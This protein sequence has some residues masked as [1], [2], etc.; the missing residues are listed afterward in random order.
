[1][2][3]GLTFY[4]CLFVL[5]VFISLFASYKVDYRKDGRRD[6]TDNQKRGEYCNYEYRKIFKE[7]A[8]SLPAALKGIGKPVA[9][10]LIG[11]IGFGI[12]KHLGDLKPYRGIVDLVVIDVELGF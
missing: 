12:F 9:E 10:A 5:I 2:L 1:M 4:F 8:Q 3:Y 6:G 7:G 11:V